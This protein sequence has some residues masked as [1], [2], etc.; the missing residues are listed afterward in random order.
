MRLLIVLFAI[1]FLVTA[2]AVLSYWDQQNLMSRIIQNPN[3]VSD[4]EMDASDI[5][6]GLIELLQL[7]LRL[8]TGI[9]FIVWFQRAYKNLTPLGADDLRFS[10]G[11][12]IG[13]WFVPFLNLV[14]P[15]QIMSDIWRASDPEPTARAGVAWKQRRVPVLVHAWWTLFILTNLLGVA[16]DRLT[17]AADTPDARLIGGRLW[18]ATYVL[19]LLLTILAYLLVTQVT[20]REEHARSLGVPMADAPTGPAAPGPSPSGPSS[21]QTPGQA[22]TTTPLGPPPGTS[23]DPTSGWS[24]RPRTEG[25]AVAALVLALVA[26]LVPV[27]PAIIALVLAARAAGRIRTSHGA[28][29]GAGVV[30]A[31]RV[32]ATAALV[33][34]PVGILVAAASLQQ[35]TQSEGRP[36][37]A[38]TPP[39]TTITAATE[40]PPTTTAVTPPPSTVRGRRA[41]LDDVRPGRCF[42]LL[43]KQ[44]ESIDTVRVV[45]CRQA[46]DEEVFAL[47]RL[48]DRPYPGDDR[49]YDLAEK[50]CEAH[51]HAYTGKTAD[52]LP[53]NVFSGAYPPTREAWVA[54]SRSATCTLTEL[55]GGQLT[56]SL[57]HPGA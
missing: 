28:L 14:R 56:G 43:N 30:V 7:L 32:V 41:H 25:L 6:Q 18:I 27:L 51:L 23:P 37:A 35:T 15:W 54:G 57:R 47:V 10:S 4:A 3:L 45:P 13:G 33:V 36:T 52:D 50:A 17:Q 11:W 29:A 8:G 12:A 38:A 53:D 20:R 40:L 49:V 44:A 22:P 34:V 1:G 19:L 26:F 39:A 2:V 21:G 5:R 31:A 46:H 48:P 42:N 16:A 24:E 55:S 9:T